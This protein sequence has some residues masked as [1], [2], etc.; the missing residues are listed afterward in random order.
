MQINKHLLAED[1]KPS[2]THKGLCRLFTK[3]EKKKW[4]E[5]KTSP[6]LWCQVSLVS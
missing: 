3:P 6:N 4:N 1:L 5:R 2:E